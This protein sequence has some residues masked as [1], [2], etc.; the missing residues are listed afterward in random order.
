[1]CYP[2]IQEEK[3]FPWVQCVPRLSMLDSYVYVGSVLCNGMNRD[4]RKSLSGRKGH[5]ITYIDQNLQLHLMPPPQNVSPVDTIILMINLFRGT[6]YLTEGIY[7]SSI[8]PRPSI[9]PYNCHDFL[10]NTGVVS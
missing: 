2:Y 6:M 5:F 7:L 3:R 1:M 9:D 4:M 8:K 10:E